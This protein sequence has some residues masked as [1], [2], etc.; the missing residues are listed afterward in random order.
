M[1]ILAG[2]SLLCI[3]AVGFAGGECDLQPLDGGG[4]VAGECC[5]LDADEIPTCA[6]AGAGTQDATCEASD[7][8][9]C[10]FLCLGSID[11]VCARWC[12]E[13]EPNDAVC[14]DEA[15]CTVSLQS[16]AG[17]VLGYACET[18]DNCDP[19]AQDCA[20]PR[21]GCYVIDADTGTTTCAPAGD[22]EAGASC[23]YL[24]DCA[25]GFGCID[26]ECSRFCDPAG[27]GAECGGDPCTPTGWLV[28]GAATEIGVCGDFG[29]GDADT[30]GDTDTDADA[31]ADADAGTA[32]GD[33]GGCGCRA[34]AA[35]GAPWA[36]AL[37]IALAIRR[38]RSGR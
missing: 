27:D 3:P 9:A 5:Y 29:G 4:C 34:G 26:G 17:D 33:D 36:A 23:T 12:G 1:R 31:D 16:G 11:R 21:D 8:C 22:G 18:P 38:R 13:T 15:L 14:P 20:S 7:D 19:L 6:P 32:G 28:P 35:G 2:S 37:A 10:G 30:D 24:N 25:S